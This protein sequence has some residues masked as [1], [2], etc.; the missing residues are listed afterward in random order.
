MFWVAGLLG[1]LLLPMLPLTA[2]SLVGA[3]VAALTS[4]MK[5][6]GIFSALFT[7]LLV[8][9]I[10]GA[11]AGLTS[12]ADQLTGEAMGQLAA[13]LGDAIGQIYPPALWYGAA[14]M[15]N[16]VL[17]LLV[18]AALSIAVLLLLVAL[19]TPGFG[20]LCSAINGKSAKGAYKLGSL[21]N[22]SQL[23][24]LYRLEFRRYFSS[25]IWI[26]NTLIGYVMLLVLCAST[27]FT[28]L[29][30]LTDMLGGSDRA[31]LLVPCAFGMLMSMSAITSSAISMEGKQWW[32][33]TSLPIS[34]G[35]LVNAK[36][37]MN[38]TFALPTWAVCMALL[39]FGL[40]PGA[41]AFAVMCT[42]SFAFVIFAVVTGLR[43][44]AAMPV[45]QWDNDARVVKQSGAVGL[46]ML[47]GAVTSI[48][49]AAVQFVLPIPAEITVIAVS[50][51]LLALSAAMHAGCTRLKLNKL[52]EK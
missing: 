15:E 3:L 22:R 6:K 33:T 41:A 16:D 32:L 28:D 25:G 34:S 26:S 12:S 20:T 35:T 5:H 18:L 52:G 14:V 4:R 7:I 51:L 46:T 21:K 17:S 30:P 10:L 31:A 40:R 50:V 27:L 47:A 23:G 48:A 8:M 24:A 43:I 19:V 2:A 42:G 11:E 45:L 37:L 49:A 39:Y 13:S 44:N 29:S 36:L 9:G 38:L 1:A